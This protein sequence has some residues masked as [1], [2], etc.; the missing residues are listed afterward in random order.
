[1]SFYYVEIS[2]EDKVYVLDQCKY[3]QYVGSKSGQDLVVS[4]NPQLHDDDSETHRLVA[5][6]DGR[7]VPIRVERRFGSFAEFEEWRRI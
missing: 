2:G 4:A 1:M 7:T 5:S 6:V 3:I